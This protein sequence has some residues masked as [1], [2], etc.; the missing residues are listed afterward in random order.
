MTMAEPIKNSISASRH[1]FLPKILNWARWSTSSG[2]QGHCASIEH[3]YV[4][5]RLTEAMSQ[6]KSDSE[7]KPELDIADAERVEHAVCALSNPV[8]REI[9]VAKYVWRD[10]DRKIT[11]N[12]GVPYRDLDIRFWRALSEVESLYGM[13]CE[14]MARNP[15]LQ[16]QRHRCVIVPSY[17]RATR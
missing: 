12:F 11:K 9:I 6:S 8:D 1:P 16:V 13:V 4:P 17:G 15:G 14:V 5:E 10:L 7:G 3:K 2:A